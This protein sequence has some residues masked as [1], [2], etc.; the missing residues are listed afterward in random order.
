MRKL[1][2]VLSRTLT[3]GTSASPGLPDMFQGKVNGY[4]PENLMMLPRS[5]F[6]SGDVPSCINIVMNVPL[7]VSSWYKCLG[8]S[9]R[10][11]YVWK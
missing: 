6:F 2:S 9:R 8:G 5:L 4:N 11:V 7:F 1:P 3:S 10:S